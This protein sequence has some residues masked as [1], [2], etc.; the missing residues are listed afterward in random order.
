MF[1][2]ICKAEYR[3][4]FFTCAD[5][6][7]PLVVQLPQKDDQRLSLQGGTPNGAFEG[8]VKYADELVE[9]FQTLDYSEVLIIKSILDEEGIPYHFSGDDF[10]MSAVLVSPARLLVPVD[11]KT[12]VLEILKD[13]NPINKEEGAVFTA[14]PQPRLH[15][16]TL[17]EDQSTKNRRF[18]K[19][20]KLAIKRWKEDPPEHTWN[21][22]SQYTRFDF[23]W[24]CIQIF[25]YVFWTVLAL[26]IDIILLPFQLIGS[27]VG[28][29]AQQA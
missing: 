20:T 14:P 24:W 26:M 7:V 29:N 22:G 10:R 21:Q 25:F 4:G 2:P 9:V 23:G 13:Y 12:R 6:S 5:C 1:C 27:F 16:E 18:F 3:E 8:E 11:L 15:K 17:V 28:K 19:Q